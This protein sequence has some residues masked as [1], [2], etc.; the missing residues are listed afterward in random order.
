MAD[1]LRG[2]RPEALRALRDLLASTLLEAE[3]GQRAALARQL[4]ETLIELDRLP[5]ATV[6][7]TSDDLAAK[8]TARRAAAKGA[9]AAAGDDKRRSRG[10]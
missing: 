6:R 7:S 10:G 5:D 4:R 9:G 3:P 1:D 8:R 2:P